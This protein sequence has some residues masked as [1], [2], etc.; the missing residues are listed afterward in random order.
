[1]FCLTRFHIS[2]LLPFWLMNILLM[3]WNWLAN[4]LYR[5]SSIGKIKVIF[6]IVTFIHYI[7]RYIFYKRLNIAFGLSD[8]IR[9][10]TFNTLTH[11]CPVVLTQNLYICIV[12]EIGIVFLRMLIGI[13]VALRCIWVNIFFFNQ[14]KMVNLSLCY[15]GLYSIF[16]FTVFYYIRGSMSLFKS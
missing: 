14:L 12:F 3:C 2:F 7:Y 8:K 11:L 6:T 16:S 15:R 10:S 1:M 4:I 5:Y 13:K 9:L